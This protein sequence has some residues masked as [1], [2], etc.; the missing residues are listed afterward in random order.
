MPRKGTGLQL[1][2]GE[3]DKL[4][5]ES[6]ALA[7]GYVRG[8]KPNITGLVVA[9]ANKEIPLFPSSSPWS[10]VSQKALVQAVFALRDRGEIADAISIANLLLERPELLPQFRTAI[11]G[12]FGPLMSP[13]MVLVEEFIGNCQPFG[14]SY[15]DAAGRLWY[16]TV[17]YA[18]VCFREK[19]NYLECWCEETEGNQDLPELQHNWSLRLDRIVDA[20][21]VPIEG[22]WRKSLDTVEVKFQLTGGLAHAYQQRDTDVAVEWVSAS[23]QVLRV[24]RRISN[25]FWFVREILP[26]G[27]D[28]V[29]REP[30]SVRAKMLEQI[31]GMYK[32]YQG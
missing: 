30:E 11:D 27:K 28:C 31:A 14:L 4:A 32:Q 19:R 23:P 13:W 20:S 9:I 5:L 17:R 15:Q 16:Y 18:K 29:V 26:Y 1:S 22:E 8:S 12:S 25:T 7:L 2:I 6:I 10:D 24:I 21:V 3:A